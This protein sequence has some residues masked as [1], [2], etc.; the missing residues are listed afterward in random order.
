VETWNS[1][2][3][4]VKKARVKRKKFDPGW[5]S[6][7]FIGPDKRGR[8]GGCYKFARRIAEKGGGKRGPAN[9]CVMN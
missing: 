9:S 4:N 2:N 6:N 1:L 3:D 8:R 5:S 7:S